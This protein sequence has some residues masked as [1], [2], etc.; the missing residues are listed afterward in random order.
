MKRRAHQWMAYFN[1]SGGI[2]ALFVGF[3][4]LTVGSWDEIWN[5]LLY[6]N[7]GLIAIFTSG[8]LS[9]LIPSE[10]ITGHQQVEKPRGRVSTTVLGIF[11]LVLSLQQHS[12][13]RPIELGNV[14]FGT[15]F[16]R[17]SGGEQYQNHFSLLKFRYGNQRLLKFWVQQT[18][19]ADPWG[20]AGLLNVRMETSPT[21]WFG[22]QLGYQ[23]MPVG[24]VRL[25]HSVGGFHIAIGG[26]REA[27][28]SRS[29]AIANKIDLL[30]GYVDVTVALP[31]DFSLATSFGRGRY[32]DGIQQQVF[33][34]M[35]SRHQEI[36]R[37]KLTLH[38]GYSQRLLSNYSPYYWSPEA[39][40]EFF[41]APDVG[42]EG[43]GFWLYINLSLD[44]ILEERYTG[45][46]RGITGWGANGEISLGF[47]AGPG[48]LYLTGRAWNSGIQRYTSGYRGTILQMSYEIGL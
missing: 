39:Y 35:I 36:G 13:A 28:L 10:T 30:A 22:I 27:I 29:N 16:I 11:L 24:T 43:N 48:Y 17:D 20:N 15:T 33:S 44:R 41:I 23:Q 5:A 19:K 34:A 21:E 18:R 26:G 6:L 46:A 42:I 38:T 40:R 31:L 37:I 45:D 4:L 32:G 47:R 7:L 3:H 8:R 2:T 9:Q 12:L 25:A 14:E 1:F